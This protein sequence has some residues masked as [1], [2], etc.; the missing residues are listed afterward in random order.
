MP[1]LLQE[2]A[3]LMRRLVAQDQTALSELYERYG[4]LVYSFSLR[5]LQNTTLA[6]EATQDTFLKV[7]NQPQSWNPDLG[8]LVSWLLTITR[9]TAIDRLR[10]EK[11]VAPATTFSLDDRV[12]DMGERTEDTEPDWMDGEL[13]RSLMQ[14][15]PPE[16]RELLELA[17]FQG[18]THT[19]LAEALQLPLG[20]VK[21]R[22]RIGLQRL[23]GFWRLSAEPTEDR[24]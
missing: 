15:L 14:R 13:L 2:D 16:Q 24:T 7:W 1:D 17:Y 10:R 11:R 9:Y 19:E 3:S 20:T 6:E 5:V 18:M 21:T 23:K 22:L 4:R 12:F 8:K